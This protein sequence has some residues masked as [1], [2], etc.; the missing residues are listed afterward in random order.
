M[1]SVQGMPVTSPL[2]VSKEPGNAARAC[3]LAGQWGSQ[4]DGREALQ[5]GHRLG[6]AVTSIRGASL[7]DIRS[8]HG[9]LQAVLIDG[10][11]SAGDEQ[12]QRVFSVADDLEQASIRLEGDAVGI[13]GNKDV[14]CGGQGQASGGG[15]TVMVGCLGWD[16][17]GELAMADEFTGKKRWVPEG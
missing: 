5:S 9:W 6:Q 8:H 1:Y 3:C 12:I 10:H 15:E 7:G 13:F 14:L 11:R 4:G 17:C 2:Q 16:R